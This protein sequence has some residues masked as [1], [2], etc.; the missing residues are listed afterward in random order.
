MHRSRAESVFNSVISLPIFRYQFNPERCELSQQHHCEHDCSTESIFPP[1]SVVGLTLN[2]VN[3]PNH[4]I[5]NIMEI[6]TGSAAL[7]C[8]T[9][10]PG[11][12]FSSNGG[13]WF[14][15]NGVEVMMEIGI[16][17]TTNIIYLGQ[18]LCLGDRVVC[19]LLLGKWVVTT[20]FAERHFSS[21]LWPL[22]G[23]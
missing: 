14:L 21:V 9:T 15:P 10:L 13:G 1:I 4:G 17:I 3:Y 20:S 16:Y 5:V 18:E 11:C 7:F 19:S 12:C 22:A 2:G 6:G 23:K 8:T